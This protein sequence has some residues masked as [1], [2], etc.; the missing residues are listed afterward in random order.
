MPLD[1][2]PAKRGVTGLEDRLTRVASLMQHGTPSRLADDA[3][4]PG[5]TMRGGLIRTVAEIERSAEREV[6]QVV[7][8]LGGQVEARYGTLLQ[9]L[10]PPENLEP[11]AGTP[12]MRYLRPPH[13]P[14]PQ[15]TS[16]E[17]LAAMG[18]APWHQAGFRGRGAKIAIADLGFDGYENL[19]GTEL[20]P[21]V[22][23]RSFRTDGDITGGGDPHGTAAA[24]IAYDVAPE[25]S[26]YLVNFTTEVEMG[27]SVDWL[28]A[29]GV[30][31]ISAS[32]GW[33]GTAYGDGIGA[34]NDIV[35]KAEEAGIVWVQAS[36][37]F[38][39][40]HWTGLYDDPDG[41]G[42][43]NFDAFDEG[44]TL[45][46]RRSRPNEERIFLVEIFL[47]WDDWD[48][49]SQDYDLFLFR[50]ET[51]VAQST[52]FQ[53]GAFPPVEHIIYTSASAG[54][55]WIGIQRFR[56]SKRA[57][58][59]LVV[60]IDYDM[61]YKVP[62]ESLVV[63]ADSPYALTVGAVEPG[64]LNLR[65][66]SSR[67]PTKDGRTKP[68]LVAADQVN[69]VTFGPGGFPG[70]S[71][72]TPYVA[73]AAAL[74]KGARPNMPPAVVREF[75]LQRAIGQGGGTKN[76]QLGAGQVFLGELPGTFVLPMV[77]KRAPLSG[78]P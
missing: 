67:G 35:K 47:T 77:V 31:V 46:L 23:V 36:G 33:P 11:L 70:T 44:N 34:V 19:L 50:G 9:L 45:A 69:T 52:A 20:P 3:W 17:G 63:P 12:G 32:I 30:H 21:E 10:V 73:G 49:L 27:N 25:A 15:E 53:N 54:D 38:A 16:S 42:F 37:N 29:Q 26:F 40:T 58:F 2:I 60:T 4:P 1:A 41:N 78:L 74:I 56:A 68:D 43:H 28:I 22:I 7:A 72:A 48:T 18:V 6:R 5:L 57:R 51:V 59:D 8:Q 39:Q 55:Y 13:A 14:M 61:E 66:Y 64:T 24:E 71:A 75:L 76:N 62:G 65:P